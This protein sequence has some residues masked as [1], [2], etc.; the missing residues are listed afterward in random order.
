MDATLD[1][2]PNSAG[3][4]ATIYL[5]AGQNNLTNIWN[6]SNA[7]SI[8]SIGDFVWNDANHNGIQMQA[9]RITS[10]TVELF[11]YNNNSLR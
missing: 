1:S 6:V 4:A 3:G 2:N 10:V 8:G 11:S 5:T 9:K 7:S